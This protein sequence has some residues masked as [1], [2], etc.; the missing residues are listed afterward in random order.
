MEVEDGKAYA[1]PEKDGASTFMPTGPAYAPDEPGEPLI[2]SAVV[3]ST[4]GKP[5]AGAVVDL[6]QT[7]ADGTYGGWLPS[8]QPPRRPWGSS[9]STCP[10]TTC[11]ARS[12]RTPR[13]ATSTGPSC[14]AWSP[15][16]RRGPLETFL[17]MLGRNTSRARHIHAYVSHEGHHRLTHQVHFDDDPVADTVSE[18]AL[19]RSLIYASVKHSDP[20]E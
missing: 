14:R 3:R 8:R 11:E 20:T 16:R 2:V 17:H 15:R 13:A 7:T 9:T 1:D 10:S 19:A 4:S 12:S 6:W 18:G 5:L